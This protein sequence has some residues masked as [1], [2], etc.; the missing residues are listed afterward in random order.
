MAK[1]VI[2]SS[3]LITI[4]K[5][6]GAARYDSSTGYL[7]SLMS[8]ESERTY[9]RIELSSEDN[10]DTVKEIF[11]L[12]EVKEILYTDYTLMWE[13]GSSRGMRTLKFPLRTSCKKF[14]EALDDHRPDIFFR[15]GTDEGWPNVRNLVPESI[16]HP[17]FPADC[18]NAEGQEIET[19]G[20]FKKEILDFLGQNESILSR[21]VLSDES[22]W[23]DFIDT[24]PQLRIKSVAIIRSIFCNNILPVVWRRKVKRSLKRSGYTEDE[25]GGAQE[26]RGTIRRMMVNNND[27]SPFKTNKWLFVTPSSSNSRQRTPVSNSRVSEGEENGKVPESPSKRANRPRTLS[28]RANE[29]FDNH[30]AVRNHYAWN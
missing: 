11:E 5:D 14:L 20:Q 2:Q 30:E 1:R 24:I 6:E 4:C 21:A 15:K 29:I 27:W 10:P 9:P 12:D 26:T 13:D 17:A 19:S 3:A 25:T 8:N 16:A 7:V 28:D 22:F 23:R 18:I